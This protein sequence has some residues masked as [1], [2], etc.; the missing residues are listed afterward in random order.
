MCESTILLKHRNKRFYVIHDKIKISVNKKTKER[1]ILMKKGYDIVRILN[2]LMGD[3][4]SKEQLLGMTLEEIEELYEKK[5]KDYMSFIYNDRMKNY[6]RNYVF[7]EKYGF[8]IFRLIQHYSD[9]FYRQMFNS[10]TENISAV[11]MVVDDDPQAKE[12]YESDIVG[13]SQVTDTSF[14]YYTSYYNNYSK[15]VKYVYIADCEM[16]MTSYK[17]KYKF[18]VGEKE[19][20]KEAIKIELA[21]ANMEVEPV[22]N[23]DYSH[24]KIYM[25]VIAVKD[26][27]TIYSLKNS[28][29]SLIA[30][31]LNLEFPEIKSIFSDADSDD[32]SFEDF[33][34]YGMNLHTS[35]SVSFC[36]MSSRHIPVEFSFM[37]K[38]EKKSFLVRMAD[39]F[40]GNTSEFMENNVWSLLE[41]K[42]YDGKYNEYTI[43]ENGKTSF[44]YLW[45]SEKVQKVIQFIESHKLFSD[46]EIDWLW[47]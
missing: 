29:S 7:N 44:D 20:Q 12:L 46:E 5:A 1:V 26:T 28:I 42:G 10:L 3:V 21:N 8:F 30:Q 11:C 2:D 47:N 41:L 36:N 6:I 25:P 13:L 24:V 40:F 32:M 45:E 34:N 31:F 35:D 15:P 14:R 18:F 16:E 43:D 37:G 33:M 38:K 4:S 39:L 19:W 27:S 22:D 9:D 23:P 17:R